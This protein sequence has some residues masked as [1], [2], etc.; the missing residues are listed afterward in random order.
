LGVVSLSGMV[1]AGDAMFCQTEVTEVLDGRNADYLL[2]VKD[3]RQ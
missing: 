2:Q 1:V 3:N